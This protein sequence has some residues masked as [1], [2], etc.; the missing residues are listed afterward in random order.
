MD[1]ISLTS[2][3]LSFSPSETVRLTAA[4]V[5]IELQPRTDINAV[6]TAI[7]K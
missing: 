5:Q 3:S 1:N 7:G 6:V 4:S 2:L